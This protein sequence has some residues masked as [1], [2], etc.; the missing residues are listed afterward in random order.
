[1]KGP[2]PAW[3]FRFME[4]MLALRDLFISPRRRLVAA[5]VREGS[6]VLD[7]GCGPGTYSIE[8]ARVAGPAGR[9]YALDIHPLAA[10]RV[11]EV[12]A[13][14]GLS[15]INTI[16]SDGATGL[17]EK[18]VDVILFY[19]TIHLLERPETVLCEMHRALAPGGTLSVASYFMR[20]RRIVEVVSDGG[21]FEY[22]GG[23]H[24]SLLFTR[25]AE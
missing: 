23:G 1:M 10:R 7:F 12:A 3:M 14:E 20:K 2:M 15:N 24:G 4:F 6:R 5:G 8:A 17:E 16:V 25:G 13:R 11:E 18:S 9:V 21:L 19:D 22:R